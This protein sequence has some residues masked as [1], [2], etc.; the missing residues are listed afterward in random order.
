MHSFL[1]SATASYTE[2]YLQAE[3]TTMNQFSERYKTFSTCDLLRVIENQSDYQSEAVEAAK[4]EINQRN[5][6]DQEINDAKS[7]LE[8]ERKEEQRQY[9]KRA[10]VEQ[11]VKSLGTSVFDTINPIQ[12]TA[13]TTER[14]IRLLTIVFGLIAVVKWFNEF[15]FIRFALTA[16]MGTSE[17]SM[18]RYILP[19]IILT[20]AVILFWIRKKSGWILITA[21]VTYS[22]IG[23]LGLLIMTWDMEPVGVPSLDSLF[24]QTYGVTQIFTT[25]FF[26]GTLWILTKNEIIKEYSISRKTTIVTIG[27]S[28]VLTILLIAPFLFS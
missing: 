15:E 16:D 3:K 10:E 20:T 28:A 19:V 18:I 26:G 17:F 23:A 12:K 22:A 6:S 21:Y 27:I 13:P 25:L 14:L 8:A 24:P 9:E 7:E 4:T 2:R 5:L 1:P 11:K